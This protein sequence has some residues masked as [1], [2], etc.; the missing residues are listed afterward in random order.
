MNLKNELNAGLF[1][2]LGLIVFVI[3]VWA[4][5]SERKIFSKQEKYFAKFNDIKGLSV[6]APVR[7]GGI[8]IGRV[9]QVGFPSDLKDP[10]VLVTLDIDA[11]YLSRIRRDSTASLQTQGL[12]GDQIINLSSG[13]HD[14]TLPPGAF[15]KVFEGSNLNDLFAKAGIIVDNT[16]AISEQITSFLSG[17]EP[18]TV[19]SI[20]TSFKSFAKLSDD[21]RS[22]EGLIHKLIY[23][24]KESKKIL[25]GTS[26]FIDNLEAITKEIR[27]GK[28]ALNTLIYSEDGEQV[29][30]S[31]VTASKRLAEASETVARV[32][33]EIE[34]GEG[35]VHN[36]IYSNPEH[37]FDQIMKKLNAAANNLE[38]ASEALSQGS[39]TLGALLVDSQLYDNLVEVTDG[40]KRSF[41]LR[42]AIR[43]SLKQKG[44]S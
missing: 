20:S 5:G 38:Q 4:L 3:A 1:V 6:G 35:L 29:I 36:L 27:T 34:T 21:I 33:S 22:K 24:E 14:E 19:E 39:G 26:K 40:A 30:S 37:S 2:A 13:T 44:K 32:S 10:S 41:L 17:L 31:L 8:N 16:M 11:K 28:G 25:D 23:S 15:V 18:G 43:G 7:L 9:D 42:Q 12:L